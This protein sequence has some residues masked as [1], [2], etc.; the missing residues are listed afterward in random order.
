MDA[1]QILQRALKLASQPSSAPS[2]NSEPVYFPRLDPSRRI[3]KKAIASAFAGELGP[4]PL[5]DMERFL[6]NPAS[7]TEREASILAGMMWKERGNEL[8][9][10]G[11]YREAREAYLNSIRLL[12]SQPKSYDPMTA[13]GSNPAITSL[14]EKDLWAE[15]LDVVACANNIAQSYMSEKDHLLGLEWLTEVHRMY[16]AFSIG[17]W[18]PQYQWNPLRIQIEE[19]TTSRMKAFLRQATI[20]NELGNSSAVA[21]AA[22]DAF[23]LTAGVRNDAIRKLGEECDIERRL[24]KRHPD[25]EDI[26]RITYSNADLQIRGVWNKLQVGKGNGYPPTRKGFASVIWKGIDRL[27]FELYTPS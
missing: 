6:E 12:L 9:K 1:E 18:G 21:S 7:A 17:K 20:F 10:K 22:W 25:P 14:G 19:F 16:D 11:S 27:F 2:T 26:S 23:A 15:F 4:A 5:R 24:K 3:P 13:T 8:Y